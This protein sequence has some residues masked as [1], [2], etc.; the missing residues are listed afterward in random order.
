LQVLAE[1]L[2]ICAAVCPNVL[3]AL[4]QADCGELL[5]PGCA[6]NKQVLD[7]RSSGL[8]RRCGALLVERQQARGYGSRSRVREFIAVLSEVT[9]NFEPQFGAELDQGLKGFVLLNHAL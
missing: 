9:L 4:E 2:W 8:E 1:T 7:G 5:D 6:A 3:D